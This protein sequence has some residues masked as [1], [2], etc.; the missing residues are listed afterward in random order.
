MI[1]KEFL[2]HIV[3]EHPELKVVNREEDMND[4]GLR[5]AKLSYLPTGFLKECSVKIKFL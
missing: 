1:N 3:E 2:A 5:S 4:A